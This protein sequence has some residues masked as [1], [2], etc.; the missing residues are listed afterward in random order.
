MKILVTGGTGFV[1]SHTAAVLA[2]HG[3]EIKMLVRSEEKMK[4]VMQLHN[5]A[6][7]DFVIGDITD[8][9][10]CRNALQDCDGL[11]HS[12][13]MVSTS[14]KDTDKVFKT[15]LE[16]TRNIIGQAVERELKQIVH[17]S[18]ITAIYNPGVQSVNEQS[19]PGTATSAYG[20]SKVSSEKFVRQLQA[21]GAPIV[22]TYPAGVIGPGDPAL[23]EPLQGLVMFLRNLAVITTTGIQMVD[24]RDVADLHARV[25]SSTPSNDRFMLGGHYY[26][27]QELVDTLEELTGRK[28]RKLYFPKPALKAIGR[29]VDGIKYFVDMEIPADSESVA[30]ACQWVIADN[31]KLEGELGF[32]FRNHKQS[33]A[34][35][36]HWIVKSGHL[37]KHL[38]GN[39]AD[40]YP[41]G[42]LS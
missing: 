11:V 5:V 28:L 42:R 37:Q 24:V 17:V 14:R 10:A 9:I 1:G 23:T 20:R 15:N 35:T 6:I 13:A 40:N 26:P 22:I 30:Y 2:S 7:K 8:P 19:P 16:G 18:S 32:T 31:S 27:W 3:H 4:R 12:A 39:L 36:L 25:F 38:I 29:L 21:L 41:A 33:L 34:D